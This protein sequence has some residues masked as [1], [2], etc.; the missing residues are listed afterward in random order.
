MSIKVKDI[1][2]KDG[3]IS[4][5]ILGDRKD[6]EILKNYKSISKRTESMEFVDDGLAIVMPMDKFH[7]RNKQIAIN[8]ANMNED[9]LVKF[10]LN[11][12]TRTCIT[13]KAFYEVE[14]KYE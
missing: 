14:K 10:I 7:L 1:E 5:V 13:S 2:R 9:E 4:W 12:T 11:Y 8:L 3:K 6:L